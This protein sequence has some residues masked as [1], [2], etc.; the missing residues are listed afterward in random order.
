MVVMYGQD[1]TFFLYGP[2][3]RSVTFFN[4]ETP[5]KDISI[6]AIRYPRLHQGKKKKKGEG[7]QGNRKKWKWGPGKRNAEAE[8]KVGL[9]EAGKCHAPCSTTALHLVCK[10]LPHDCLIAQRTLLQMNKDYH[11]NPSLQERIRY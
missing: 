11:E 3:V 4:P 7:Q 2:D 10:T 6:Y 8:K 5:S 9:Q 1:L